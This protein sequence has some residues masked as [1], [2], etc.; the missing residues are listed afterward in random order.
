MLKSI[1]KAIWPITL[2]SV[3]IALPFFIF[4]IFQ[5]F[6]VTRGANDMETI[7]QG[8]NTEGEDTPEE[9]SQEEEEASG[10][11][12][13]FLTLGDSLAR[14]T[15]DEE[16]LGFA[17]R[18]VEKIEQALEV[19]VS[20]ENYSLEGL[21]LSAMIE[22][23]NDERLQEEIQEADMIMIS[24]GGN[25]ARD[26][27][28]ITHNERTEVIREMED[29]YR[30]DLDEIIRGIREENSEALVVFLGLYNL[31]YSEE[32]LDETELLLGW[33]AITYQRIEKE[34]DFVWIPTYDL[35]QFQLAEV[36]SLDQLHPNGS[37]YEKIANRIVE[38]ILP[39]F[40]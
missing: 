28:G 38:V 2:V 36:L 15:G 19:P 12:Y 29:G 39:Y 4:G 34:K 32:N 6:E 1:K 16:N 26:L 40:Q 22:Q 8:E 37:G 10:E 21:R 25:D 5:S 23:L 9:S 11:G 27:R 33:N 24:I 7:T 3:I 30:K 20:H 31:D 14:G 17:G 35:F 18:T 13:R